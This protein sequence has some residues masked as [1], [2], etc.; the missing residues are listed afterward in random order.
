M[1]SQIR[2]DVNPIVVYVAYRPNAD[3]FLTRFYHSSTIVVGGSA[4]DTNF[5]HY[6]AIDDLIEQARVETDP[7]AQIALWKEAQIKILEDMVSHTLL[8]TNQVY[9][10]NR[11]VDYGHPLNNVLNLNPQITEQTTINQ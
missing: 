10:R 1:H 7:E 11:N 8:Y 4:P 3:A 5:S 6:D 2:Q 9:A